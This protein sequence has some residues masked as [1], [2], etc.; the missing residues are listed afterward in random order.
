MPSIN[1]IPNTSIPR[2]PIIEIPL[3]QSIP[4]V[5][6]VTKTLP[7]ALSM[8]CVTLRNDGTKNSQLFIDDPSGN[9]LVCPIPSY[10]PLQYDK[11]KILLVEEEKPPT[12]VE[13]PK[14][15]TEQPEVP[16]I[17][18]EPPCP[19]PKKNNPRIGDLNAKGTEKVV[20][21]KWVEETKECVVQYEATTIVEK[22]LPS[23][24]TV[25]T[26]FAITVV[27]TTA[28]TLT[29]IL[30]RVLKPLFKQAIGK[31]KKAIGK[32]GTKFSGKKPMKSK[33]NKV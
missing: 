29:P 21:F 5:S 6:H 4:N 3:E 16:K 27:A 24:N 2:I 26:T 19:D 31:V 30:N 7:P 12:N 11:K 8:P 15:E 32:K 33:I 14:T 25:S 23:I 9:R 20:G 17:E 10:V 18:E 22:Y 28:A 1:Q 13:P